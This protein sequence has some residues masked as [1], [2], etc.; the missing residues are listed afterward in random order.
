MTFFNDKP[1]NVAALAAAIPLPNVVAH[2]WIRAEGQGTNN[3]TNLLNCRYYGRPGQL[4][5]PGA[6]GAAGVGF[7]AY[8]SVAA[9]VADIAWLLHNSQYYAGIRAVLGQSPLVIA[10]AIEASPWAGGHYGASKGR[11]GTIAR[12]VRA[13]QAPAPAPTPLKYKVQP[14]DTLSAIAGKVWHDTSLW[15]LIY[16]ANSASIETGFQSS[17]DAHQLHLQHLGDAAFQSTLTAHQLH[18][19]HLMN[20]GDGVL[21]TGLILTIPAK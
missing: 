1:A 20:T 17:L 9:G 15:P 11:D 5:G 7:A 19:Q 6:T 13:S 3:P 21:P 18:L 12:S 8:K 2:A 16:S 4:K 10:H 14:G